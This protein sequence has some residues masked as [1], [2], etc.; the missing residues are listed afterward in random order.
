[1]EP[2]KLSQLLLI[3]GTGRD[4]GK[5]T[6]ACALI[7][8]FSPSKSV[9]ALKITPHF[10]KNIGSGKVLC[11]T[12]ELFIAEETDSSTGKDSSRMLK[13]GAHHS[14]FV[15]TTDEHLVQAFLKI[16]EL[17]LSDSLIIC[18][19]GGL[20]QYVEPGLFLMM[21][22]KGTETIKPLSE[23]LLAQADCVITFDGEKTGFNPDR[24]EIINNQWT[25]KQ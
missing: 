23:K 22:K 6:L 19:S 8:K 3:A 20:R 4:S 18:E 17:I 7:Q 24:I 25:L 10:H 9:I 14:F 1:M 12:D 16:R 13:A 21:H 2:L 15:M 11:N 5:T